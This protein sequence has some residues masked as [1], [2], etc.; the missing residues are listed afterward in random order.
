M[1]LRLHTS[2]ML[3]LELPLAILVHRKPPQPRL[4][5]HFVC[6]L[7]GSYIAWLLLVY[8]ISNLTFRKAYFI[9]SWEVCELSEHMGGGPGAWLS[10]A[11]F[12]NVIPMAQSFVSSKEEKHELNYQVNRKPRLPFC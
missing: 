1:P 12:G 3:I 5:K 2:G 6:A 9:D 10:A 11:A 7:Q 8:L 4:P